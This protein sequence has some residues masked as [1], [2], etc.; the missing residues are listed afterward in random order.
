MKIVNSIPKNARIADTKWVFTKKEKKIKRKIK[1]VAC[2]FQQVP[3]EDFI[4]NYSP[5]IQ[6]ERVYDLL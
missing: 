6:A 3:G 5:T 4:E 2:G 1:L